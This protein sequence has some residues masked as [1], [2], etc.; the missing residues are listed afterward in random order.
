MGIEYD[1]A[2]CAKAQGRAEEGGVEKLVSIVHANV[3]DVDLGPASVI[4]VYLLPEGM[5]AV[6]R[7]LLAA[8]ERGVR[9]V[10][11]GECYV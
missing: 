11:Y 5:R 9:V 8:L 4:F 10:T 1:S 3:L 2:L 6:Q 7:A